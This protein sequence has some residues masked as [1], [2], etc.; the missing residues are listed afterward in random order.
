MFVKNDQSIHQQA[1]EEGEEAPRAGAAA[2]H[3]FTVTLLC[4]KPGDG[5]WVHVS[6][7]DDSQQI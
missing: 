2:P 3:L 1:E 7:S 5:G 6:D 4:I